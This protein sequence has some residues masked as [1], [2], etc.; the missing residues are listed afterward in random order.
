MER[1]YDNKFLTVKLWKELV[2][3]HFRI[4]TRQSD[5]SDGKSQQNCRYTS[6]IRTCHVPNIGLERSLCANLV[7]FANTKKVHT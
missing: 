5:D 7:G 6:D 3:A 2:E 1:E 4:L